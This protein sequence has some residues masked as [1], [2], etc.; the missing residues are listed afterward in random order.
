MSSEI[1][2]TLA[3]IQINEYQSVAIVTAVVYDFVLTFPNEIE[4]VWVSRLCLSKLPPLMIHKEET[5]VMGFNPVRGRA[6]WATLFL[7]PPEAE[8]DHRSVMWGV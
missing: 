7:D 3:N 1:Q 4:Y 8:S 2:A 5:L 6:Y